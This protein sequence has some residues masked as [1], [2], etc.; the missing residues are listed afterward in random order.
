M[1]PHRMASPF[2]GE[3]V[4]GMKSD[5]IDLEMLLHHETEKAIL[6]SDDGDEKHAVWIPKS[7]C[8][9]E[10]KDASLVT[11]TMPEWQAL[12]KGLI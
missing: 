3:G 7:A 8:E 1:R 9:F 5:L 6:I 4:S 10:R 11:V 2:E 12:D